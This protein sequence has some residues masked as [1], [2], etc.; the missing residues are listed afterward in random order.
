MLCCLLETLFTVLTSQFVLGFAAG[1]YFWLCWTHPRTRAVRPGHQPSISLPHSEILELH[2]NTLSSCSQKVRVC[3]AETG[4]KHRQI[5]HVLPSSGSWETKSAAYLTNVNPAGTVPVLVHDGHP[6][7]ESHE[8]IVYIDQVLMPGGPRLTPA[9]PALRAL[10]D[11]WV[12]SGSMVMSEVMGGVTFWG[13]MSKRLGNLLGPMT[14]PL[15]CAN[16]TNNFGVRELGEAVLMAPM[17]NDRKFIVFNFV[18]KFLGVKALLSVGQLN[19]LVSLVR[20]GLE[21]HFTLLSTD[22]AAHPGP[23]LC[24]EQFTLADVSLVPVFERM[25]WAG[26]WTDSLRAKFP[27]VADYWT[28]IQAREGYQASRPDPAMLTKMAAMNAQINIWKE[29]HSWFNDF[30]ERANYF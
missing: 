10:M 21:H 28:A 19:S 17:V 29:K 13:G 16:I 24:G 6:V 30:F 27:L 26:W 20:R 25:R 1:V 23:F 4:L 8:Q 11:K 7:Y 2:H 9:D 12:E 18:F 5:H 14:M 15:F 3:L 22:L